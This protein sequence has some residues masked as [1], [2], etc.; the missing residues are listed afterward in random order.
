MNREVKLCLVYRDMWQSSGKFMPSGKQ[1]EKIAEPIINMGCWDR[2]ETN[3]GG[4][5]QIQLLAGENPN[6][7][8]RKWTKP[9]NEAKIKTQMLERGLNALSMSPVSKDVRK[10]MFNVK[11]SQGTNI[12]R[13][14]DGLNYIRNLKY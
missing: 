3:G 4:F 13:S 5:E 11:K 12:S 8:L 14:F 1:L 10:L 2:I 6:K 7:V 9:F